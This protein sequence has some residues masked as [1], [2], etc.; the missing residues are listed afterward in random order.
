MVRTKIVHISVLFFNFFLEK[1]VKNTFNLCSHI[2]SNTQNSNP[3][4]KISIYY[5]KEQQCQ[6][7]FEMFEKFENKNKHIL[8]YYIICTKSRTHVL[9]VC[10]ICNFCIFGIFRHQGFFDGATTSRCKHFC[11][12]GS[13]QHGRALDMPPRLENDGAD[14]VT[15]MEYVFALLT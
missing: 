13:N 14:G 2:Q 10:T 6:N 12:A 4:F 9:N 8:F 15:Q 5:K 3:I 1:R 7:T 11:N